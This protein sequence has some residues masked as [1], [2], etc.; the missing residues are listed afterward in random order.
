MTD[1]ENKTET[2]AGRVFGIELLLQIMVAFLSPQQ[3]KTVYSV[4][5]DVLENR[6]EADSSGLDQG[7]IEV[8][9]KFRSRLAPKE[10]P[11]E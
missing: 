7:T 6:L 10:A 8:L 11:K 5:D 3:K 9:K 4:L 1:Q 2:L